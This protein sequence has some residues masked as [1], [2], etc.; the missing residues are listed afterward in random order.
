MNVL[1]VSVAPKLGGSNVLEWSPT[2]RILVHA[3][4]ERN[5]GTVAPR[6]CAFVYYIGDKSDFARVS[7]SPHMLHNRGC[8]I[9]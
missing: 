1:H 5:K 2:I 7:V 6:S 9:M 4:L 3:D 8:N